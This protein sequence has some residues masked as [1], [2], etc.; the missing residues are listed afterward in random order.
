VDLRDR[1]EMSKGLGD[2]LSR[3]F[4]LALTPIVVGAIGLVLDRWLG[5]VPLLTIVFAFWGVLGTTYLAWLR[6]D[7]DMKVQEARWR[8][9]GT[10]AR[11]RQSPRARRLADSLDAARTA[12]LGPVDG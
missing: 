1:R 10:P 5:L 11:G 6:Y 3:A 2:G 12:E 7:L 4:E 8:E 9:G